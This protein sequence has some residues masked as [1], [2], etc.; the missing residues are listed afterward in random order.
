MFDWAKYCRSNGAVKLNLK[1]DHDGFLPCFGMLF[2]GIV[3]DIAVA[4]TL[5]F[6][7]RAI[8]VFD[9]G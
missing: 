8:V 2:E 3:A 9:R 6:D 4:H 7:P 1:L 5:K